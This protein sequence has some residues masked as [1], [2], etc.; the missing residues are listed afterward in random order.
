L[1]EIKNIVKFERNTARYSIKGIE[2]IIR[3]WFRF[4]LDIFKKELDAFVIVIIYFTILKDSTLEM[5]I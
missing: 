5:T 1:H 2:G 3:H 4:S